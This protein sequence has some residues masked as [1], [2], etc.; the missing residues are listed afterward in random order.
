MFAASKISYVAFK[1]NGR[2]DQLP[3]NLD[4]NLHFAMKRAFDYMSDADSLIH[5]VD[6]REWDGRRRRLLQRGKFLLR[7]ADIKEGLEKTEKAMQSLKEVENDVFS[8]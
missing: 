4:E 6:A 1:E 2:L 7:E 5:R 3:T 8:Q